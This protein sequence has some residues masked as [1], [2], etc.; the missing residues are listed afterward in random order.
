MIGDK[1]RIE[2]RGEL[3]KEA[4]EMGRKS[5]TKNRMNADARPEPSVEVHDQE[6]PPAGTE[7]LSDY[8]RD[9]ILLRYEINDNGVGRI[10]LP[11]S[12]SMLLQSDRVSIWPSGGGL[13][14]R[15]V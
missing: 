10:L 9:R 5:N 8:P 2:H 11:P 7:E 6:I 3:I 15:S 14:I 1:F 4:K 12:L 13:F